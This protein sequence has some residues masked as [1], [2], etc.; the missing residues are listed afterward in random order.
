MGSMTAAFL[1]SYTPR[2]DEKGR[3]FLPAKYRDGLGEKVVLT[4][5]PDRCVTIYPEAVFHAR[6]AARLASATTSSRSVR[7]LRRALLGQ[8]A[9]E[10]PDRQGRVTIPAP[11]RAYA[12][13]DRDCTV[14]GQGDYVEVWDTAAYAEIE[15]SS[16]LELDDLN[17]DGEEFVF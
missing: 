17:A 9:D 3:L 16:N 11:L 1:G 13:L 5:G 6:I 15:A 4:K 8:A 2:L 14:V 10:A 7:N 12:G